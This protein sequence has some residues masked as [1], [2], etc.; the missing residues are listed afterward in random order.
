MSKDVCIFYAKTS[1][2]RHGQNC[3]KYHP[4]PNYSRTVIIRRLYLYP[5]N[6]PASRLSPL[7][8]QI[9]ADL[10]YEDWFYELSNFGVLNGLVLT[11]NSSPQLL[12]NIY[13]EFVSEKEAEYCVKEFEGRS[14][15][16]QKI[17]L[18]LSNNYRINDCLCTDYLKGNCNKG[19]NCNYVHPIKIS[20]ERELH[21]RF[22][23]EYPKKI[24]SNK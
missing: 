23:D 6:N 21:N 2:C 7:S 12:G 3:V 8:V 9:H 19:T 13:A 20:V 22:K 5:P 16:G 14:Y 10:F 17:N 1:S 18:E 11:L 15:C 4:K 24:R